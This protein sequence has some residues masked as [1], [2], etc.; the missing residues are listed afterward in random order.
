MPQ[1]PG[2]GIQALRKR[3]GLSIRQLGAKA[4][5]TAGFISAVE[6]GK[7][8]PSIATLQRILVALGTDLQ[9]FFGNAEPDAAGPVYPREAMRTISDRERQYTMLLPRSKNIPM[10]LLDEHLHPGKAPPPYETLPSDIA[11]YVISGQIELDVHGQQPRT[12]RTGDAF[13]VKRGTRH[14]GYAIGHEEARLIT[15]FH[16]SGY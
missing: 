1:P 10:A 6:R 5:V 13:F 14:R 15:V 8:S 4:G 9:T 2:R 16:P 12:V 3:C 7:N 11:G